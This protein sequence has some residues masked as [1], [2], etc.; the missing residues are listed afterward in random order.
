LTVDI[1][2]A[3]IIP[4]VPGWPYQPA[5]PGTNLL[6]VNGNQS[7][8]ASVTLDTTKLSN[9]WHNFFVRSDGPNGMVSQ[10][11]GCPNV[12]SHPAGIA[13]FWFYVSN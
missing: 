9:G 7:S 1:D 2:R 5:L 6:T 10:C 3:H 4:A 13:K 11:S 8:W 12:K